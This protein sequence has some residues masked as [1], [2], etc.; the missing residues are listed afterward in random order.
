[1]TVVCWCFRVISV[2]FLSLVIMDQLGPEVTKLGLSHT[3][4]LGR[5]YTEEQSDCL[6][7]GDMVERNIPWRQW[8]VGAT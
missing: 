8:R 4:E 3:P 7:R 2:L 5:A 1:M 6:W